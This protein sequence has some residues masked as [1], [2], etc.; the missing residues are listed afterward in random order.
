MMWYSENGQK[1][2]SDLGALEFKVLKNSNLEEAI[3]LDPSEKNPALAIRE[4]GA[5]TPLA[6]TFNKEEL[7]GDDNAN[8][9]VSWEDFREHQLS[10]SPS[11]IMM[12]DTASLIIGEQSACTGDTVQL[13][14]T[15]EDFVNV[16]G[17]QFSLDWDNADLFFV[18]ATDMAVGTPDGNLNANNT[19]GFLNVVWI[20]LG[21]LSTVTLNDGDTLL[22]LQFVVSGYQ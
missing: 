15:V 1:V 3:W 16:N 12:L 8:T 20:D 10:R 5:I 13:A 22:V 9:P 19:I 21:T 7:A 6:L 17:F 2:A 11:E 18:G 4:D 14:I